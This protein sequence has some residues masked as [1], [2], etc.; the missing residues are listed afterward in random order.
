MVLEKDREDQLD[1]LCGKW[2]NTESQGVQI[3]PALCEKR[4]GYLDWSH[5]A[6]EL[7]SKHI[8]EIKIEGKIEVTGRRERRRKLLLDGLKEKRGY[9]KSKKEPLYRTL[10]R[11][12]FASGYGHVRKTT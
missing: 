10:W 7:P 8:I 2:S 6:C 1:Q 4:K 5:L 11:S 3:Y 9:R 12:R